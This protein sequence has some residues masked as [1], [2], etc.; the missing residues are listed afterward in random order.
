MKFHGLYQPASGVRE[1]FK[2]GDSKEE[3]NSP[4]PT[5]PV[6]KAAETPV[7]N[8][9]SPKKRA[10]KSLKG[11]D[12]E[13]G[14]LAMDDDEELVHTSPKKIKTEK[15]SHPVIKEEPQAGHHGTA[16][17]QYPLAEEGAGADGEACGDVLSD[18]LQPE[19]FETQN[20]PDG[21]AFARYGHEFP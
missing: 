11:F 18:F 3:E 20:E 7:K 14:N 10:R 9:S 15:D 16:G 5:T 6:K 13:S 4:A 1:T 21:D 8:H 12:D 17:L 19:D 2:S